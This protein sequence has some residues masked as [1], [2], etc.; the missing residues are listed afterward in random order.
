MLIGAVVMTAGRAEAR[1]AEADITE[2]DVLDD[3]TPSSILSDDISGLKAKRNTQMVPS[4]PVPLLRAV[5]V[6][7]A[8][9][10]PAI[11]GPVVAAQAPL[12]PLGP[13]M[14]LSSMKLTATYT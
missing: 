11:F 10:D 8:P 14:P 3:I 9:V 7:A 6:K 12:P 13:I 2:S 4:G 5:P 1:P